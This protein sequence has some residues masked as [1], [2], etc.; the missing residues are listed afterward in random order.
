MLFSV[1]HS[2]VFGIRQKE[3]WTLV[4]ANFWFSFS[5]TC[6]Q[7]LCTAARELPEMHRELGSVDDSILI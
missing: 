5:V 2:L 4:S 6:V 3:D 1:K 7:N